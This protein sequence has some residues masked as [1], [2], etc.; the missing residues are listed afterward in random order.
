MTEPKALLAT[1]LLLTGRLSHVDDQ[2]RGY[3]ATGQVQR[4]ASALGS[5]T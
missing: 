5:L 4:V 2:G 3:V 1:V